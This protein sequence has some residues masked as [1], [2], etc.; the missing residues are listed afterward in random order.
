MKAGLFRRRRALPAGS[1]GGFRRVRATLP[2]PH[3]GFLERD[4]VEGGFDGVN[5]LRVHGVSGTPPE[6]LLEHAHTRCVAGDGD[7][8]F[9]RRVW[10]SPLTSQ[11]GPAGDQW[12]IRRREGYCWGGLTSGAWIRALYLLLLPFLLVNVGFFTTPR[13]PLGEGPFGRAIRAL[14]EMAQRLMALTLTLMMTLATVEAT[15][16][17]V[18]WQCGRRYSTCSSPPLVAVP[19]WTWLRGSSGPRLA[20]TALVPLAVVLLLWWLGQVTWLRAEAVTPPAATPSSDPSTMP[21]M[22]LREFWNGEDPVA[23]LRA[24]HVTAAL[25]VIGLGVTAPTLANQGRG[26]PGLWVGAAWS[27]AWWPEALAAAFVALLA[28]CVLG[29]TLPQTTHRERP[30]TPDQPPPTS[31]WLPGWR[32]A[33]PMGALA[34]TLLAGL[35]TATGHRSPSDDRAAP[36]TLPWLTSSIL[37]VF[38]VQAGLIALLTLLTAVQART[39]RRDRAAVATPP[40]W[41]GLALPVF[42]LLGWMLANG[43]STA[44][45]L[46]VADVVGSP[47]AAVDMQTT[48]TERATTGSGNPAPAKEILV[49]I[50]Y[51]WA[52]AAA[53]VV[54]LVVL[55]SAV[56]VLVRVHREAERR[57][58][59]VAAV[60]GVARPSGRATSV[61]SRRVTSIARIWANAAAPD[62]ARH[63]AGWPLAGT[64]LVLVVGLAGYL[65]RPEWIVSHGTSASWLLVP[66]NLIMTGS[67]LG[68]LYLGRVTT[69]NPSARR[70]I[71]ILWDVGTFWP[72]AT[73]PL[74]PPS[75]GERAVPDLLHRTEALTG[76]DGKGGAGLVVL[77]C[78]SQGCVIG[79]AVI[80]ASRYEVIERTGLLTYGDPLR[81]L[82]SRYFPAY[83]GV[84][85]LERIGFLLHDGR[86]APKVALPP[87]RIASTTPEE[88]RAWPWRNL[89]RPSDPIGG[90]LFVP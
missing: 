87:P 67:V 14:S 50:G 58:P 10:E 62:I 88:R 16:D 1:G 76:A 63:T 32:T 25:A 3:A 21:P 57:V 17:I 9:H 2:G 86:D 54:L 18:G 36:T 75:Y 80:A 52:A 49:P 40:A 55:L 27:R 41:R 13:S 65:G 73:H 78:H 83:F 61:E 6:T 85:Q 64:G 69:A 15:V 19:D 5:E 33:L 43:L 89:Q 37:L 28:I 42:H 90:S 45:V 22:E 44:L 60:Y 56:V 8:G 71:G 68:L 82:Y 23:R 12:G 24:L 70:I 53:T 4:Y 48:T 72:R 59:N 47:L 35:A 31:G 29:V 51:F 84:A 77:S 79:A 74:A 20:V 34:L 81:R 7:A 38:W 46:R 11:D 30:T 26:I 39:A 66:G